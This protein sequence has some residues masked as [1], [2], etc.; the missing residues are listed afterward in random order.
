MIV[1]DTNVLSE[2]MRPLPNARVISWLNSNAGTLW[3]TATTVQEITYGI[4]RLKH[5]AQQEVLRRR[6][7]AA[8][9]AL[10]GPRIYALDETAGRLAGQLI[11]LREH[12]GRPL[13]FADAHIAAI[14]LRE[15]AML[16]TRD[17][18]DFAGL[19]LPIINPWDS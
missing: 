3:T 10:I 13:G 8:L 7:E 12:D 1:L 4:Q 18:G 14:A 16:A 6:L 17:V 19:G 2:P 5:V 9:S 15:T 11:A